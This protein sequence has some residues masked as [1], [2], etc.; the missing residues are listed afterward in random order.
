M[1]NFNQETTRTQEPR[2]LIEGT[3]YRTWADVVAIFAQRKLALQAA[4]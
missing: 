4:V 2:W 1:D 3:Y